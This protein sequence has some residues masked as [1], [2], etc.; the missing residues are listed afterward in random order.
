LLAVVLVLCAQ[1]YCRMHKAPEQAGRAGMPDDEHIKNVTV[2]ISR[3]CSFVLLAAAC[4]CLLAVV[5]I[6]P[7]TGLLN[8]PAPVQPKVQAA[9]PV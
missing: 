9:G 8:A 7:C 3:S 4:W 5:S 6:D 2:G 1:G